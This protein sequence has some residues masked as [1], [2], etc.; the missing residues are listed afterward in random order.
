MPKPDK[1]LWVTVLLANMVLLVAGLL[2]GKQ[3]AVLPGV[4]VLIAAYVLIENW[5]K[6]RT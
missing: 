1:K 5:W 6:E 3:A 2:V 4:V